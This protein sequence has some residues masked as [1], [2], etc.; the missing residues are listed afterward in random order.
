MQSFGDLLHNLGCNKVT[1]SGEAC[2]FSV[3][4]PAIHFLVSDKLIVMM[5]V[6]AHRNNYSAL[7]RAVPEAHAPRVAELAVHRA[8]HL[9]RDTKRSARPLFAMRCNRDQHC[10][11]Q[12][13]YFLTLHDN[14]NQC[15]SLAMHCVTSA[16]SAGG[17]VLGCTW[18][19]FG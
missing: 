14:S 7:R 2:T 5:R 8:A 1:G 6:T 9:R 17:Q 10:L 16:H 18:I 12:S 19:I 4:Q 13:R 11:Y 3:T 15:G